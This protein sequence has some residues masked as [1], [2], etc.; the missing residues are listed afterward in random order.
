M[1]TRV[2]RRHR[3]AA[4]A[5]HFTDI[6]RTAKVSAWVDGDRVTYGQTGTFACMVETAQAIADAEARG[7][8]ACQADVTGVL[9]ARE[10]SE[11]SA[12]AAWRDS[13]SYLNDDEHPGSN[14]A[15]AFAN[16]REE[17]ERGEHVGKAKP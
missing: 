10:E 8:A 13:E 16:V 4:A 2:E 6:G 14:R 5:I 15:D 12:Y 11:L 7:Y 1:A 17:I 9:R 3:E